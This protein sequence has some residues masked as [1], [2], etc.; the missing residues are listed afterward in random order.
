MYPKIHQTT[1]QLPNIPFDDSF[2][3]GTVN[4]NPATGYLTPW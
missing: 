4:L 3:F 2:P 1:P